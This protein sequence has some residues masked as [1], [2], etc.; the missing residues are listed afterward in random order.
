[1]GG[2]TVLNEYGVSGKDYHH[3]GDLRAD[4]THNGIDY[5]APRGA[6]IL[7][8]FAGTLSVR[9]DKKNGKI[10][11]LVDEMGNKLMGIH[12]DS[13][14]KGILEALE[15]GG[16]QAL[17]AQG[18][19]I[20]GVGNTGTTAGK[21][22]HLH[23]MGYAK[24]STTPVNPLTIGFQG[25]KGGYFNSGYGASEEDLIPTAPKKS[26]EALKNEARRIL[27]ALE[28]KDPDA[29]TAAKAVL[30]TFEDSGDR[31]KAALEIVRGELQKAKK[32]VSEFGQG[33]DRL[34]DQMGS[35]ESYF[36][37]N[38]DAAAYASSLETI[39]KNALAA[40]AAEKKRWG[41]TDKFKALRDLGSDAAS[42]ARQQ[43]EG[44][45]REQEQ[46]EKQQEAREKE[47]RQRAARV[48]EAARKGDEALAQQEAGRLEQMRENDLRRA[49]ENAAAKLAVEKQYRDK[50][51]KAQKDVADV[52]YRNAMGAAARGPAQ[53]RAQAEL[54]AKNAL[55]AAYLKADSDAKARLDAAQKAADD[56][57]K[58][59]AKEQ[60]ALRAKYAAERRNLDV[61]EAQAT[62]TRTQELN[63]QELK[64]FKG[65][66][67]QRVALI[68]RQAQD[69]FNAAEQAARAA[70]DKAVREAQN[71]VNNPN[72]QRNIDAANQ[73]Y[74]DA[75]TKA[76][77]AQTNAGTQA[78]EDQT[79]AVREAR[80]SYGKLAQSMRDKIAAGKVEVSDLA[81]Y[82][83]AMDQAAQAAEKGGVSQDSI[84]QGR[85]RECRGAV[86]AGHRRPDRGG[87][88]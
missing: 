31:A 71:D 79:K 41:E 16:G 25:G 11:E 23:L 55:D 61:Q 51:V 74:T 34:K 65:T 24:D 39:S 44:L 86:P 15:E 64:E 30:K 78:L 76:G 66:Q 59:R 33:Y 56:K 38:D 29:L 84:R 77:N 40:A 13:F 48:A 6:P 4:A 52:V 5:A 73:A 27:K 54:I 7:A 1:M 43:R 37:L 12:L 87:H 53:N 3:D 17:I 36:R 32:E 82:L 46:D 10:F 68:K 45:A 83:T 57:T 9:E 72:K 21:T 35:A 14:D 42:K 22:P 26:G 20:G 62:L 58:A 67:A 69:E 60:A 19:R 2:R 28:T 88:V 49:G 81:A 85:A 75:V 18:T 8:P 80:D 63:A 50:T 70:R 47:A